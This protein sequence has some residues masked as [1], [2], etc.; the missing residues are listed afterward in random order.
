MSYDGD[1]MYRHYPEWVLE[2]QCPRCGSNDVC[3]KPDTYYSLVRPHPDR[4][5]QARRHLQILG[6]ASPREWRN[7]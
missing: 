7:G 4:I 1:P 5:K 3:Y 6:Y 2:V